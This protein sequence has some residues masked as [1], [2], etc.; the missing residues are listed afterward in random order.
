MPTMKTKNRV[1][2]PHA[3]ETLRGIKRLVGGYLLLSVLTL[4]AIYLLR[5]HSSLVNDAVWVRGTIV[6]ASG[7]MTYAFAA[8]AAHGNR[9]GLL[10]V[11]IVSIVMLV[12]IVAI[13]SL[14]GTFPMWMKIEQGICGLLLLRVAIMANGKHLRAVLASA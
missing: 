3:Q 1:A 2:D 13:I 11:R 6:V 10:R 9:K 7:M 12:A 5:H 14:P 4:G 8:S